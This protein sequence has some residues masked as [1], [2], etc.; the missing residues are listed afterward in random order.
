MKFS[1]PKPLHTPNFKNFH[2]YITSCVN[3]RQYSVWEKRYRFVTVTFNIILVFYRAPKQVIA[4]DIT[5]L[6]GVTLKTPLPTD[7]D[8]LSDFLLN[9]ELRLP[10]GPL[11][12]IYRVEFQAYERVKKRNSYTVMYCSNGQE[13]FGIEYFLFL[14]N[15][16]FAV[17]KLLIPITTTCKN[18]FS[19]SSSVLDSVKFITPVSKSNIVFC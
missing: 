12:T 13:R 11:T 5:V 17:L 19:L 4:S 1:K 18:H 6:G 7:A 16:V 2:R 3:F 9:Y 14:H 15:K 10:P 8:A